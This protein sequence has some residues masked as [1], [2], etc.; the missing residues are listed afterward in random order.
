MSLA[1]SGAK[2]GSFNPK[3]AQDWTGIYDPA[4]KDRSLS[5]IQP[6]IT[7]NFPTGAAYGAFVNSPDFN[8]NKSLFTL[9]QGDNRATLQLNN[10]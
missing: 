6:T 4:V 7:V 5:D 10:N 8:A 9:D 3:V 2:L 1:V